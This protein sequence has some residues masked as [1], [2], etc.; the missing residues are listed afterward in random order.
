LRR[1]C[2]LNEKKKR[3]RAKKRGREREKVVKNIISEY[4]A[5]I[6]IN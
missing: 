1:A 2:S 4:C 5:P 3:V 6:G